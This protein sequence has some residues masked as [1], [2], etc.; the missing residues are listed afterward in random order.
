MKIKTEKQNDIM[1]LVLDGDMMGGPD[2]TQLSE[3]IHELIDAG[4]KHIVLDMSKVDRMNSSG[5]GILI[6]G[7]TT[8]R[9]NGGEMKLTHMTAKVK[10]LITITKLNSVFDIFDSEKDAVESF[11]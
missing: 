2:A 11:T 9:A 3:K 10:E 1:V 7:L 6:G 8:V 5:L 4:Q